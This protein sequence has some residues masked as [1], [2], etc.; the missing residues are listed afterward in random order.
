MDEDE[1]ARYAP[2][3]WRVFCVGFENLEVSLVSLFIGLRQNI[4]AQCL[5]VDYLFHDSM[6]LFLRELNVVF[7]IGPSSLRPM[8][9]LVIGY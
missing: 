4:F 2:D 3:C 9:S 5:S 8:R 1:P 7:S 6:L